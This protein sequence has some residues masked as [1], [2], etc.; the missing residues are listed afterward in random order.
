MREVKRNCKKILSAL[1][2]FVLVVQMIFSAPGMF[3]QAAEEGATQGGAK[4][5][6]EPVKVVF[7]SASKVYTD[8]LYSA[9]EK[10]ATFVDET[11]TGGKKYAHFV[12]KPRSS[13]SWTEC[14]WTSVLND[15]HT[16][17]FDMNSYPYMKISYRRNVVDGYGSETNT[18]TAYNASSQVIYTRNLGLYTL[19][20]N[21]EPYWTTTIIDM[22]EGA[23]SGSW[24]QTISGGWNLRLTLTKGGQPLERSIDIEYIAFFATKEEA[25]AYPTSLEVIED[26]QN[27]A[28]ANENGAFVCKAGEAAT[29]ETA[30]AVLEQQ[31]AALELSNPYTVQDGEYIAPTNTTDGSYT[32]TVKFDEDNI[33]SVTLHIEK[34]VAAVIWSFNRGSIAERLQQGSSNAKF[35]YKDGIVQMTTV[36]PAVDDGFMLDLNLTAEEQY[37]ASKLQYLKVKY[38]I[39]GAVG[40]KLQFYQFMSADASK[41]TYWEFLANTAETEGDWITVILDLSVIEKGKNAIYIDNVTDGTS[42]TG[43]YM[44]VSTGAITEGT[45]YRVR[46]NLARQANMDRTAEIEYMGLFS[47]LQ[48]ARAFDGT[49]EEDF[50]KA[51]E[52]LA[53]SQK[54]GWGDGN[55]KEKALKK[56]VAIVENCGVGA[57]IGENVVYKAPTTTEEGS[58]SVNVFLK[59]GQKSKEVT[60]SAAIGLQPKE[61]IVWRFNQ[62]SM[63]S[64]LTPNAVK[65]AI[66]DNLLKMESTDPFNSDGF[67]FLADTATLGEQFYLQDYPYIQI[68]YKR[69]IASVAQIYFYSDALTGNPSL[70]SGLGYGPMNDTWYTTT[71]DTSA[72]KVGD[73]STYNYNHETKEWENKVRNSSNGAYSYEFEG[74]STKFRFNFGRW[75][76]L[77]R[78]AEIEYIAFFPTLEAANA[79]AGSDKQE[80]DRLVSNAQVALADISLDTISY[81]DGCTENYAAETVAEMLQS[82]V[83]DDVV[84]KVGEVSSDIYQAPVLGSSD[85]SYQFTAVIYDTKGNK[86]Y[87]TEPYTVVISRNADTT[88]VIFRFANPEFVA[89]RVMTSENVMVIAEDY[90]KMQLTSSEGNAAFSL[91]LKNAEKFHMAGLPYIA[92]RATD[93]NMTLLLNEQEIALGVISAGENIVLDRTQD[94]LERITSLGM[95]A[96]DGSADS[97]YIGFFATLEEAQNFTGASEELDLAVDTLDKESI[98]CAYADAKTEQQAMEYVKTKVVSIVGKNVTVVKVTKQ[99]FAQPTKT[100]DGS[101]TAK[102]LLAAGI[103]SNTCYQEVTVTM[104]IGK[105]PSGP[106]V[107]A[108]NGTSFAGVS[109]NYNAKISYT[110][111]ALK[112][113]PTTASNEG[114]VG[115]KVAP[116]DGGFYLQDYPYIKIK[117]KGSTASTKTGRDLMYI[118]T[119]EAASHYTQFNFFSKAKGVAASAVI[120]TTEELITI[121]DVEN[122]KVLSNTMLSGKLTYRGKLK[123]ISFQFGRDIATD[124][125]MEVEYVAFFSTREEAEG[126]NWDYCY[127][128]YE[129]NGVEYAETVDTF[130]TEPKTIE[131]G[132]RI[133]TGI[134]TAMTIASSDAFSLETT[135]NGNVKFIYQGETIHTSTNVNVYDNMWHHIAVTLGNGKAVLY[136]DNEVVA[137]NTAFTFADYTASTVRVA[138]GNEQGFKGKIYYVRV[139]DAAKTQAELS[140]NAFNKLCTDE[141]AVSG[142]FLE[143]MSSDK[144]FADSCG[145]NPLKLKDNYGKDGHEFLGADYIKTSKSFSTAAQPH[146]FE[147]WMKAGEESATGTYTI[148]SN[149]SNTNK[150]NSDNTIKLVDGNLV[151]V[152][153]GQTIFTEK[154]IDYTDGVWRHIAINASGSG[155]KLYVDGVQ[156]SSN[157]WNLADHASKCNPYYIGASPLNTTSDMFKGHLSDVRIWSSVRT[158][159][160]IRAN[161]KEYVAGNSTGLI[162]SWRLDK[163]EKLV[164]TD[165]SSNKNNGKLYSD[166]WYK[167]ENISGSYTIGQ[168][169]DTQSYFVESTSVT[170]QPTKMVEFFE[171][172]AK[173]IDRFNLVH[174]THAGD[175]TQYN[176]PTEWKY[177]RQAYDYLAGKLQYTIA[178]GN[179]DYPS[180]S[181]GQGSEYRDAEQYNAAFPLHTIVSEANVSTEYSEGKYSY[182][183]Y[184]GSYQENASENVYTYLTVG[185]VEYII[186]AIEFGPSDEVLNWVGSVLD[187][188]ENQMK[189]AIITTHSYFSQWGDLTVYDAMSGGED[190]ATTANEGVDIWDKLLSKHDNIS[191]INA[192]HS[193]N[194]KLVYKVSETEKKTDVVQLLAD[195]SAAAK[196]FPSQEGLML[197]MAF[198]EDGKTMHTYYYSPFHDAFYDTDNEVT[199]EIKNKATGSVAPRTTY[200]YY[201]DISGYR[202]KDNYTAPTYEYA[203]YVFAGWYQDAAGK[204][205]VDPETTSGKGYAKFVK[206][207]VLSVKAQV[208]VDE[209]GRVPTDSTSIRFITTVDALS[210]QAVA[211]MVSKQVGNTYTDP[212]STENDDNARVVYRNLYALNESGETITYSPTVFNGNSKYFKAWVLKGVPASAYNTKLKVTPYWITLDGTKVFGRTSIKTISSYKNRI[213]NATT[214]VLPAAQ[215]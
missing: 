130:A 13:D 69:N 177:T 4:S 119:D 122:N 171:G 132:I 137:E 28:T 39:N 71:I 147:F 207:D 43:Q 87:E 134:N 91:E 80:K 99:T 143:D 202:A 65:L 72:K 124:K 61:P 35:A 44:N 107:W 74:L 148:L 54:I 189:Q 185:E 3:A 176:T 36:N 9:G 115:F 103:E 64:G 167:L 108:F 121:C 30:K 203:G 52:K 172:V 116:K 15:A 88:P 57:T 195:H 82:K 84:V 156:K 33:S 48:E 153:R 146:T 120:D 150:Y 193:Q 168:V 155:A 191:I 58:I 46:M 215:D 196:A 214:D 68:K 19:K 181:S 142:W 20:Q 212:K 67:Y 86:V 56:I 179:H 14:Q 85:G 209:N 37:D 182:G 63:L 16:T 53:Q 145:Q 138:K 186:F 90:K 66:E 211:F 47:T 104:A 96:G 127:E 110:G 128:G 102:I 98:A 164:Y 152:H 100:E 194:T 180:P 160:E 5:K 151:F 21:Q 199:F 131:A 188:P 49:A 154:T 32:T 161:M 2:V 192:G 162:A 149:N 112:I 206:E 23:T 93:E 1:C 201:D 157:T 40:A 144:R 126:Y 50:Q 118:T 111:S 8:A 178:L 190:F 135:E 187:A 6:V 77:D 24:N 159:D 17:T 89:R 213:K 197:M 183:T 166:G 140:G 59:S 97:A 163:Q 25:E 125:T 45:V 78:T 94:A 198:S 175:V 105:Q 10:S 123:E 200:K 18:I 60:A 73:V 26:M 83:G 210:Y 169:G 41:L 136:V 34:K 62:K 106:I 81:Y 113:V 109:A 139:Y 31:I 141:A 133:P 174:F 92:L 70:G 11:A 76:Y 158:A 75:K 22:R 95:K 7:D 208:G 101:L 204:T 29:A 42:T 205:A 12:T 114:G 184:G 55:T 173:N 51:E 170:P 165:S 79:Y 117:M 27:L 38:K 129:F